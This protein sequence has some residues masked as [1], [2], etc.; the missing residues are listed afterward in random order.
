MRAFWVYA[1]MVRCERCGKMAFVSPCMACQRIER[2][3]EEAALLEADGRGRTAKRLR[4]RAA[5]A[6]KRRGT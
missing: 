6:R 4:N 3:E 5:W 1:E 2:M